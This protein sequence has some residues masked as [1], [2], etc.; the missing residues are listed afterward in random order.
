MMSRIEGPKEQ[1]VRDKFLSSREVIAKNIISTCSRK[2]CYGNPWRGRV[3]YSEREVNCGIHRFQYYH[4]S[5]RIIF[6]GLSS[7]RNPKAKGIY[8]SGL[9][10]VGQII[11]SISH[12]SRA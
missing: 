8:Y 4:L 5:S 10:S 9:P 12:S 11:P 3:P 1:S 2:F 6:L 7:V